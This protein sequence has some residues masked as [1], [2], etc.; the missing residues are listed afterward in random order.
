MT[1]SPSRGRMTKVVPIRGKYESFSSMLGGM[2]VDPAYKSGI[3]FAFDDE[4]TMSWGHFDTTT[5]N[6]CMAL[7]MLLKVNSEMMGD[8]VP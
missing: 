5:G 3:T 7:G 1:D 4:G 2:M 6:I 8:D